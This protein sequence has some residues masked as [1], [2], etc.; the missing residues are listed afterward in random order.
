M[1]KGIKSIAVPH[2]SAK[3]GDIA[4]TVL[5]PGDPLRAEH[6]AE[7]F[8]EDIVCFNSVRN[9][10]GYTGTYKGVKISVMG[11]GMGIPSVGIYSYEL[12][13]FY[14]VDNIIRVGSCGAY[15]ADLNIYDIVLVDSAYSQ[16]TYAFVQNGYDKD[17]IYPTKSLNEAIVSKAAELNLPINLERIVSSDCFYIDGGDYLKR[18]MDKLNSMDVKAVEMESFGLFANA[19]MLGKSAACILTVS[20]NIA[21]GADTTAIERQ[22][23]F[24]N[25]MKLGLETAISL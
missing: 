7:T 6:I 18:Y 17:V 4:K 24:I 13:K 9:M 23:A 25:M 5:L 16:S 22:N 15:T 21:T 8:L 3:L 10:L 11:S 14:G 12:Y 2:N 1:S 20:D 19:N